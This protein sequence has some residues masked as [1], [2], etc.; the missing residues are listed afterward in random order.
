MTSESTTCSNLPA[1]PISVYGA[2]GGVVNGSP[3]ICGGRASPEPVESCYLFDKI[4]NNSYCIYFHC[5]NL[6]LTRYVV[7][8]WE[9]PP[10]KIV[11]EGI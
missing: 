9:F 10:S 1:Y 2:V 6:L 11:E 4:T 3:L 7:I 8:A 5:V